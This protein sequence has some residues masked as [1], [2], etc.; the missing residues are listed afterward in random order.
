M[1]THLIINCAAKSMA[2]YCY[3][4]GYHRLHLSVA[5][6]LLP[7]IMLLNSNIKP[8]NKLFI[9]ETLDIFWL[10]PNHPKSACR[11]AVASI[12]EEL[13]LTSLEKPMQ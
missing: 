10:P 8:A 3:R 7:L 12:L 5:Q 2:R 6:W 9:D 4:P 11:R 13:C 1:L